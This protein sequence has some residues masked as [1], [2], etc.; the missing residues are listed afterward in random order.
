MYGMFSPL[1][2]LVSIIFY[3]I[4]YLLVNYSFVRRTRIPDYHKSEELLIM[5][6]DIPAY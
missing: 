1:T 6:L 2:T 3:F 5:I 4:A